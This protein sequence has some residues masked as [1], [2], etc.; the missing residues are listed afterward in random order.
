MCVWSFVKIILNG[1]E[2][3]CKTRESL[4]THT[5]GDFIIMHL[6]YNQCIK[7]NKTAIRLFM[8]MY[9]FLSIWDSNKDI[10]NP[11]NGHKMFWSLPP[12]QCSPTRYQQ[13]KW[14]NKWASLAAEIRAQIRFNKYDFVQE[15]AISF[16]S[17]VIQLMEYTYSTITPSVSHVD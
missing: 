14:Q 3:M 17:Y 5:K 9:F 11:S 2:F 15:I 7:T 13:Q 1:S 12:K 16:P 8:E 6:P 10:L 4:W